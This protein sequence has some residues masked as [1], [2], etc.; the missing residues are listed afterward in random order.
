MKEYRLHK[1]CTHELLIKNGFKKYG[2][3]YRKN[4]PLYEYKTY[5][6][7]SVEFQACFPDVFEYEVVDNNADNIYVSF[8]NPTE[9]DKKNNLVLKKVKRNLKKKLKEL[10]KLEI[11]QEV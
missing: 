6:T 1:N 11:I 5:P 2:Q 3:V 10:I 4:I 8:Y 7:V 9:A